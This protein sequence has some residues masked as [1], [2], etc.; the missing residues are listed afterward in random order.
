MLQYSFGVNQPLS[1]QAVIFHHFVVLVLEHVAV[2]H[3]P[4]AGD[5]E[6]EGLPGVEA[7]LHAQDGH[8]LWRGVYDVSEHLFGGGW[9]DELPF[10]VGEW[11]QGFGDVVKASISWLAPIHL[12]PVTRI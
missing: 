6:A 11:V 12:E 10:L 7:E 3:V 1:L 5:V 4:A 2:V 9:V 8:C